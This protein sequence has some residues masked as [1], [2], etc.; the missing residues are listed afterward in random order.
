[1][2]LSL[3]K[4]KNRRNKVRQEMAYANL[5]NQL[6]GFLVYKQSLSENRVTRHPLLSLRQ[7]ISSHDKD[8]I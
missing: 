3:K 8:Y 5:L 1:M 6:V 4:Q 2:L 7:Y